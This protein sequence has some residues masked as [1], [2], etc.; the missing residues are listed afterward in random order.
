[1]GENEKVRLS[2]SRAKLLTFFSV[3]TETLLILPIFGLFIFNIM[4]LIIF[5]ITPFYKLFSNSLFLDSICYCFK[6]HA[7][8]LIS[9]I[10]LSYSHSFLL[11]FWYG[12]YASSITK[13]YR[14][15]IYKLNY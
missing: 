7:Y 11:G 4:N 15:L 10:D 5:N 6:I 13:Y 9:E 8:I 14:E 2:V 12:C 1:M 3:T